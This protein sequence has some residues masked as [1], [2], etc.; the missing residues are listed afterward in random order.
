MLFFCTHQEN[1][2]I[3]SSEAEVEHIPVAPTETQ[4]KGGKKIWISITGSMSST[5]LLQLSNP[6]I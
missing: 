6:K 3:L 5:S 4:G 2:L 1:L